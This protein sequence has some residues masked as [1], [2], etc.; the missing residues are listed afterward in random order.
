MPNDDLISAELAE[1]S[2]KTGTNAAHLMSLTAGSVHI[3]SALSQ[4]AVAI[5]NRDYIADACLPVLKV[6]KPSDKFFKWDPDSYFEESNPILSGNDSMP[7]RARHKVSTDNFSCVDYGLIDFLSSKTE[8]SADAPLRP[9]MSL[10]R[11]IVNK[12]MLARERRVAGLVFGSGNYGSNTAALSGSDRWDN[13]SSNPANK[14]W[15]AIEACDVRPNV[16]VLGAQVWTALRNNQKFLDMIYGRSS[17]SAGATPLTPTLAM[18][19]QAFDLDA[20]LVGAAK[21]NT[22][23]EGA[24]SAKGYVWGKSAALIRV[25]PQPDM[26]E[27]DTFGYT[28]RFQEPQVELISD[29]KPGL[30][31][32]TWIKVTH[33]DDEKT[34][35]GSA[36]GYLYTTVVN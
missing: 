18:V 12:L 7:S 9:R 5:K 2:A 36:A 29:Q 27:T 11:L 4:F 1:V 20:V 17:T 14:I 8:A 26:L 35:A 6:Q 16:M 28:F 23:R 15:E 3:D 24:T 34:V 25:A 10:T 30:A 19:A 32:G 22:N 21:Y 33:S 31:G 13:A